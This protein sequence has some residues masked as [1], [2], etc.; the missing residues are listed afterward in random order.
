MSRPMSPER[1]TANDIPEGSVLAP[2]LANHFI[3]ETMPQKQYC[4]V[5]TTATPELQDCRVLPLAL[6]LLSSLTMC[7]ST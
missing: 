6:L 1:G 4:V 5:A 3:G 7:S 2:V